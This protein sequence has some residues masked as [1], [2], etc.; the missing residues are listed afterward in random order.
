MGVHYSA[1]RAL[2]RMVLRN[3][4]NYRGIVRCNETRLRILRKCARTPAT[5][6]DGLVRS[7]FKHGRPPAD[8]VQLVDA[9]FEAYYHELL[10]ETACSQTRRWRSRALARAR[11]RARDAVATEPRITDTSSI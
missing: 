3:R 1:L 11:Q 7:A 10:T 4:H 8:V 6:A 9:L 2:E 5:L